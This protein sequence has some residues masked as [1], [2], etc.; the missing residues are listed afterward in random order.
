L[1]VAGRSAQRDE[2]TD[3]LQSSADSDQDK[4]LRGKTGLIEQI[5]HGGELK[6][7]IAVLRREPHLP[8]LK[9]LVF[10]DPHA[11]EAEPSADE[12]EQQTNNYEPSRPTKAY[13]PL[14]H[15]PDHLDRRPD[16]KRGARPGSRS[17]G[18]GGRAGGGGAG[19]IG[20]NF[21]RT[22]RSNRTRGESG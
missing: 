10:S 12:G 19:A 8:K 1:D 6:I 3:D 16:R 21:A 2:H 15:F 22:C 4:T 5:L 9:G 14:P 17:S 13:K 7:P 11:R 20:P 18:V